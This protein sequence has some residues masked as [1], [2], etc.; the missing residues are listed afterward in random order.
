MVKGI[1]MILFFINIQCSQSPDHIHICIVNLNRRIVKN[2]GNH[3]GLILPD[4]REQ[5]FCAKRNNKFLKAYNTKVFDILR[6]FEN[7]SN[8]ITQRLLVADHININV[9]IKE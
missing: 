8:I 7:G 6:I 5:P 4:F 9:G 2:K 3:V 1:F